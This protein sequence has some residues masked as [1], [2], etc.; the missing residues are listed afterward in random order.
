[1]ASTT[2][3]FRIPEDLKIRLDAAVRQLKKPKNRVITEA[4]QEYLDRHSPDALRAEARRQSI[5]A[6][7]IKWKDEEFWEKLSAEVWRD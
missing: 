4:L 5:L 7:K 2:S 6:S 1:M 3:S